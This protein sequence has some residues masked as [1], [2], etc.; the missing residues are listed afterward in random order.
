M[1]AETIVELNDRSE[2]E[3]DRG[4]FS[5]TVDRLVEGTAAGVLE[6]IEE[7]VAVE[8]E[9]NSSV[10]E[11]QIIQWWYL[12]I[13][14]ASL[15]VNVIIVRFLSYSLCDCG[16]YNNKYFPINVI[17]FHLWSDEHLLD[18]LSEYLSETAGN[19]YLNS[20]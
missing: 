5:I 11:E 12:Q 16:S 8:T 1:E 3:G 18:N 14:L 6:V 17:G 15:N 9:S 10:D 20:R 19:I 2:E 7:V 4:A 13:K